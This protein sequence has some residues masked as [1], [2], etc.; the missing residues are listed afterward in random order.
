MI[1]ELVLQLKLGR[2][3]P[4]YFADKYGVNL[5]QRFGDQLE[6]LKAEGYL[7]AATEEEISLTRHGLLRVDMLLPR[8]FLPQH[9]GIRYT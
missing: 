5:L 9:A 1:R 4:P 6:T 7:S 2:V 8:F 3:R